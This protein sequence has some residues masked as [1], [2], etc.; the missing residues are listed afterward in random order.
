MEKKILIISYFI[1]AAL[2]LLTKAM[3]GFSYL[4]I[5]MYMSGYEYFDKDPI[6][7]YYVGQWLM[8]FEFSGWIMKFFS[9]E[10]YYGLRVMRVVLMISMEIII[11]LYLRHY[12]PKRYIILGLAF[13]TIAQ[14]ESYAEINY[15]DYSAFFLCLSLLFFHRGVVSKRDSLR[16]FFLSGLVIGLSVFFR[17]TNLSFLIMPLCAMIILPLLSCRNPPL[18]ILPIFY[19]GVTIG[20]AA[21]LL[22]IYVSGKWNVLIM[23]ITDLF[24]IGGRGD[25]PHHLKY[26]FFSLYEIYKHEIQAGAIILFLTATYAVL[27]S[28]FKAKEARTVLFIGFAFFVWLNVYFWE[29][30]S[31]V[32]VGYSWIV[33]LCLIAIPS[34]RRGPVG[35]FAI[36]FL[37]PLL[38]PIGTNGGS[39][40]IGQNLVFL[41]L[42]IAL[43]ITALQVK[44]QQNRYVTTFRRLP[45]ILSCCLIVAFLYTDI[46]RPM[47][48]EE[49]RLACRYPIDSPIAR[50]IF[51]SKEN[52]NHL[53]DLIHQLKGKYL[54]DNEYLFCNFN[55][56]IIS[57]LGC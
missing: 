24:S 23:T 22:V 6:S 13:A 55:I 45:S 11:Y 37:F 33:L 38:L 48:E 35:L 52:A 12:I 20:L 10:S 46:K 50:H 17:M 1:L 25:D 42:P 7:I 29:H 2:F 49:C 31:D 57:L 56:P 47:L 18:R 28:R 14:Q 26:V 4:D 30:I 5:G 41:P 39:A 36:A 54:R 9:L 27:H 16:P 51:T 8:S 21:I 53:N 44:A 32:I 19:S 15:N 43:Y 40:F 3:Q 34:F